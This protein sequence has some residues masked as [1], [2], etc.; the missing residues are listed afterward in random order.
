MAKVN[1][2]IYGSADDKRTAANLLDLLVFPWKEFGCY[3][4][5]VHKLTSAD[6]P[7]RRSTKL[8]HEL[9][10]FFAHLRASSERK[11]SSAAHRLVV[12]KANLHVSIAREKLD[13]SSFGMDAI[14]PINRPVI[15]EKEL[16]T[17]RAIC[18]QFCLF[19]KF[20]A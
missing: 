4:T 15:G 6:A 17:V 16:W 9:L 20:P 2:G 14:T 19:F 5:P 1:N 13:I 11:L 8:T 18:C 3:L 12:F 7:N 10:G